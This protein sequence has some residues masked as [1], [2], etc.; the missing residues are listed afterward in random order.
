MNIESMLDNANEQF[1]QNLM[2]FCKSNDI[3]QLTPDLAEAFF[4]TL[5]MAFSQ[6]GIKAVREFIESYDEKMPARTENGKLF[7]YKYTGPKDFLTFFGKVPITRHVFQQDAGGVTLC[8]LDRMW[9]M[10]NEYATVE[11]REAVLYLSAHETPEKSVEFFEKCSMFNLHPTTIKRLIDKT[12]EIFQDNASVIMETIHQQEETPVQFDA[13]VASMDGVNVLLNEKGPKK[14]RPAERPGK[15]KDEGQEGCAY[16]N[17][18]C[19]SFS[20]YKRGDGTKDNPPEKLITRYIAKMP[21][22]QAPTF[23]RYFEKEVEQM[24]SHIGNEPVDKIILCDGA[25]SIW[26]YVGSSPLF[27][28]FEFLVDFYHTT[29]HLSKASEAIFGKSDSDGKA[30]YRKWYKKLQK[31]SG[32]SYALFRSLIHYRNSYQYSE[33]RKKALD[34]EITFFKRNKGK[35]EYCEFLEAG[36]P[37]GSGVVEAACKSIVRQRMCRSGQRWSRK[38]GDNILQFR[39]LVKSGRWNSWWNWYKEHAKQA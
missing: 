39:A 24:V 15:E 14:G 28:D 32:A 8:P 9:A 23:K 4:R 5:K 33:E 29:E 11:V 38:K 26:N 1:K 17:A 13:I 27:R 19:G 10:E 18:M 35:M 36:L 31:E 7:R 3:S 2:S 16:K 37:I 30:W 21:E 25:R 20:Y 6:I 12:G 22:D 34:A